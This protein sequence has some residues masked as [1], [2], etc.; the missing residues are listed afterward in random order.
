MK[1]DEIKWNW[2]GNKGI[3]EGEVKNSKTFENGKWKQ[4]S[5]NHAIE[6]ESK[7]SQLNDR[8]VQDWDENC[9]KYRANDGNING[10][11]IRYW[12]DGH[13]KQIEFK[14]GKQHR[15]RR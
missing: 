11:F 6:G 15:R 8:A 14:E 2:T 10:K 9:N 13:H 4:N 12:N 3:Y 5:A 1:K 7:N